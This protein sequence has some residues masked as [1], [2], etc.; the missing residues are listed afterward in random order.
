MSALAS[1]SENGKIYL[2][3]GFDGTG[4]LFAPLQ[5]ALSNLAAV[6]VRYQDE[7]LFDDYVDSVVALLP[8]KDAILIAES[9]SGPIALALMARYP[10]R[11]KC[12][13]L[14]ATFAVSPYRFLTRLSQFVPS[15]FFRLSPTQPTILRTF[16]FDKESDPALISK[17]VS[18]IRSVPTGTIKSRLKVLAD[19]DLRPLLSRITIPVLYL[20]AMQ[21]KIV[22][23]DLSKELVRGL[24]NITVQEINGPHLL[25]QSRPEECA[26]IIR[27]FTSI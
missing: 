23:E 11:I 3:P 20:Q 21:D 17:A 7:K 9:F 1:N 2:L 16:C 22:S 18:V 15:L 12:A 25:L 13:V 19:I 4:E 6:A 10:E 24:S 5:L 14:C 26:E 8:S 27:S